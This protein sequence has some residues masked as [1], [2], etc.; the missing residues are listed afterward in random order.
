MST[1][2]PTAI[3]DPSAKIGSGVEVGANV[4]IGPDCT[5]GDDCIISP[6]AVIERNVR[7]GS[8]VRI[9]I[10]S[11]IGGDPQ[12]LKYG[13]E[14]TWV[15]IGDNTVVREYSTI[16][17]GT[18]Q[19]LRTTVGK[20]CFLMSYVHLAHDCHVGNNVILANMAQLAGHVQVDDNAIISAMSGLHQFVRVGTFAFVGGYSKVVKDVPPY[21]KSD[22]NPSSLYGLNSV[23]LKR[24]GFQDNVRA[25]LKRAY[26]LFFNSALNVS[27]ARQRADTELSMI[28]EVVTFLRFLDESQRGVSS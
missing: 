7:L 14:E 17:R 4:I 20:N 26:N 8:R 1:I 12:D 6:R 5:I 28:P 23:G 3:I 16:N 18:S 27:Q 19:S 21:V 25:E 11:V 22:G 2:H 10:G 9:G 15:E 13:G 24:N